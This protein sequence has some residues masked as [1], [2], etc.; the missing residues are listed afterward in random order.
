M[1]GFDYQSADVWLLI[2]LDNN[3]TPFAI[4][5]R[6]P[7]TCRT[8]FSDGTKSYCVWHSCGRQRGNIYL[9]LATYLR[10]QDSADE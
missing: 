3:L 1:E 7:K 8:V 6:I 5:N 10:E 4:S 2:D 9:A